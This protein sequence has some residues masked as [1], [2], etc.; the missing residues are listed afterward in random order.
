MS[1]NQ[2][3]E[4][5]QIFDLQD[6][7]SD[8]LNAANHF[9][10]RT[11]LTSK[12]FLWAEVADFAASIAPIEN[13]EVPALLVFDPRTGDSL[14][15]PNVFEGQGIGKTISSF[16]NNPD[17]LTKLDLETLTGSKFQKPKKDEL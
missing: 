10:K 8:Y 7:R 4:E 2:S 6:E 1:R 13:K 15:E 12:E 14:L 5:A 11:K 3:N 16:L 17:K 9:L